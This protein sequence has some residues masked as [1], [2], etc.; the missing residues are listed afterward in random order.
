[1]FE[2]LLKFIFKLAIPYGG[3]PFTRVGGIS[4]L[5]DEAFY[6]PVEQTIVVV[7]TGAERKKILERQCLH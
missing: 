3:S 2:L 7:P 1:M 5:D 6:V 4:S